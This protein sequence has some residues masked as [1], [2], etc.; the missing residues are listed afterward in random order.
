MKK[1]SI[2]DW[3]RKRWKKKN[4]GNRYL[5]VCVYKKL[6]ACSGCYYLHWDELDF[7]KPD[8]QHTQK[9][10]LL[11]LLFGIHHPYPFPFFSLS[12][13]PFFHKFISA[14]VKM[15]CQNGFDINI[16]VVVVISFSNML[17]TSF[18][19]YLAGISALKISSLELFEPLGGH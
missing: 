4:L 19:L 18:L 17:I 8:L 6:C 5:Y 15:C 13:S 2:S 3:R 1:K 10:K 9:T 16:E 14:F 12:N 11:H 7:I